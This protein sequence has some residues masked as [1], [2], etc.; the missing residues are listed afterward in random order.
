MMEI[1]HK[2]SV[3]YLSEESKGYL[4]DSHI[5]QIYLTVTFKLGRVPWEGDKTEFFRY[6]SIKSPFPH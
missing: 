1:I 3:S 6:P 2:M 4:A 5:F